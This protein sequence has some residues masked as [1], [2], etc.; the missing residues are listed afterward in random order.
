M[1]TK[2]EENGTNE[3]FA[4]LVKDVQN[5]LKETNKDIKESEIINGIKSS[6]SLY[7]IDYLDSCDEKEEYSSEEFTEPTQITLDFPP[8]SLSDSGSR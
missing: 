8:C 1:R 7:K 5:R 2:T 4:N 3:K 6:F